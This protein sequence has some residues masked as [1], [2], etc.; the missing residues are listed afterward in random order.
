MFKPEDVI[1]KEKIIV[2]VDVVIFTIQ[3]D[4]LK[5]LLIKRKYEPFKGQWALPGGFVRQNESLEAAAKRELKE[6]TNVDAQYL[7][8]LYSF[9]EPKRDPRGRVISITYFALLESTNLPLK[10][11]TDVTDV[12]WFSV[13]DLPKLGFDHDEILK[14]S[15]RRL[16]WKLEYTSVAFSLLP[17][18]FTLTELQ[19][20]YEIIFG[21]TFDKRNFRK[22]I[23]SLKIIEDSGQLKTDVAH[24]P[25]KLY[26]FKK[27][28][29]EIVEIL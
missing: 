12:Q 17:E 7:E 22:K 15:L 23:L 25:A 13:K 11:E 21:K 29:G 14:Y 26:K 5:I 19:Q 6:E 18:Q 16:K 2:A 8:Q 20:V 3:N 24:R 27:K 1:A 9:G 4:A 28:I 10:A